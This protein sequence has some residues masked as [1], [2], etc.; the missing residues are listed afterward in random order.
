MDKVLDRK[1]ISPKEFIESL[2]KAQKEREKKYI[3]NEKHVIK[4]KKIK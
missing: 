3:R 4:S 2:E 1:P